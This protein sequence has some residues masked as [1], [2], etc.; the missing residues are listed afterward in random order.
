MRKKGLKVLFLMMALA[1][2][3]VGCGTKENAKEENAKKESSKN[4]SSEVT[5]GASEGSS[6]TPLAELKDSY[7]IVIVGSGGA[8]MSAALEAKEKGLNPVIF[9]KMAVVGG[10]TLK[11]SS[12][13]N[14]SETKFQKEEG[15]S[16]SNDLFYEE[17]LAGGHGTNDPEMLRFFVDHSADAIDWLD[18]MG[19]RLN[20]LTITGG[21]K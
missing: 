14:A 21:M 7:D 16:D 6:Y 3:I 12:G 13:M 15:I 8:G 10:N 11:S 20:N 17:T 18:S 9:E 2:I 4:E 1:L 19:I 5:T